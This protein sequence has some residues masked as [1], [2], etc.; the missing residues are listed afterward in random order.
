MGQYHFKSFKGK[1]NRLSMEI[2]LETWLTATAI[3]ELIKELEMAKWNK[4]EEHLQI[5]N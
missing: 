4:S 3:N 5:E 1:G 2:K